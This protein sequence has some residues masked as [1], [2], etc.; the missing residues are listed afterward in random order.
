VRKW[1]SRTSRGR[2]LLPP[3]TCGEQPVNAPGQNTI[4]FD[5][6]G[7]HTLCPGL[8]RGGRRRPNGC[9]FSVFAE[10]CDNVGEAVYDIVDYGAVGDGE[11]VNT[12]AIQKAV[13]ACAAGGGGRVLV[14][15]GVFVSGPVFLRSNVEFHLSSGA[16][17]RGSRNFDD[18]PL[19]DVAARGYHIAGWWYASLLT[20][21]HLENVSITGGGVL[22]GQG[23]VWWRAKDAGRLEHIRP[24][25][26]YLF[27]CQRVRIDGVK[28][29]NSPSWTLVPIFCRDV[30]VHGVTVRNP[31]KPYHNCDGIDL[32]SCEN[33]R[34]ANCYVDTGDDGICLKSVPD[35]GMVC[36]PAGGKIAPDY[37][38][39]RIP[40]ENVLIEN[41]VVEHGHSGVGIW[42]EVI[43]GLRNI[44]VSNCIFDGTRTGIRIARYPVVGGYVRHV[45][46]DNVVMRRVSY[47][48]ELSAALAPWFD[49]QAMQQPGMDQSPEFRDIHFSNITA[50]QAQIA[51]EAH[52][53]PKCPPRDISF[54]NIRIEADAGFDLRNM[55]NVLLDNVEV[56][57]RGVPLAVRDVANL[58]VRRF[59][60]P[61]PPTGVPV[62]QLTH[63][64][65]AW[66]HG[67]TAAPGTGVFV[68]LAGQENRDLLL[69]DNRLACAAQE[70]ARVEPANEWS[71]CS[72]AYTGARWVRHSGERNPWL[73]V[74]DAVMATL[75][76]LWKP[77][78][79]DRIFSICRVE[80]NARN[81]A[82]V[83]DQ[84]ERRR[85]YIIEA[86]HVPERLI[87]FEDGE[88]LRRINDPDFHAYVWDG[89]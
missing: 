43:G 2:L 84:C 1:P 25:V 71:I 33:V 86:H 34:V 23:E 70:L 12:D 53:L 51:C 35:F 81:G 64:R 36:K 50:T 3:C 47:V 9:P 75:Y 61:A 54:S 11:T 72:H 57:C 17:L 52:G 85:I 7:G 10:R 66:I 21:C 26:V 87:I 65:N 82:E 22:D 58:E 16:V 79:I 48:F 19:L 55:E 76:R 20:G 60:A 14:P 62:I 80:P 89:M 69:E 32:M 27:D 28:M 8:A 67:C 63:T 5:A 45:R 30:V 73:P 42:A 46:I 77:D 74:S 56:E 37:S 39:P 13:D 68:G 18:Y 24:M 41:C 4:C 31:W 83:E 29:L 40:C 49:R 78:Q 15:A 59:C 38:L 6:H 88:L 44:A